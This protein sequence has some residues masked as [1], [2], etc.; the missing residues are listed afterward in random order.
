M[1]KQKID[2]TKC[3]EEDEN[4]GKCS[5]F[6]K[7]MKNVNDCS[8]YGPKGKKSKKIEGVTKEVKKQKK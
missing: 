4:T 5:I 2:C 3:K 6:K 7:V 1:K 8:S